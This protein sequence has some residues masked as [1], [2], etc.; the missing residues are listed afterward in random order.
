MSVTRIPLVSALAALLAPA[1]AASSGQDCVILL[2]G[3]AR[4]DTSLVP[5]AEVLEADGYQVENI[6]Y[7]S[8]QGEI[9]SLAETA[10]DG[11]LA[12]CGEAA[13]VHFVTHSMGG[14][15]VRAWLAAH[16]ETPVGHVVMMSPPNRGS[17]LVDVLES[18][19]L[20]AEINGPAGA[21]LQTGESST[22]AQLPPADYSL[23]IIA[24]N[25]TLNPIA[26]QIIAGPDDGKVSVASTRLDGMADH[27]TL[28]V[29]HT[30]MMLSPLV[31]EQVRT[32]LRTGA[33]D[34]D[35]TLAEA[36]FRL[37]QP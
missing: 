28:P 8:T 12:A 25:R 17:E 32:Y 2:H 26:S 13:T 16:P 14:I 15:L 7:P 24:G 35:L 20:F 3:L 19:P 4:T 37:S 9:A 5:M 6:G 11:A 10:V 34:H 1:V 27:V 21:E 31:I 36:A 18:W 33:F 22:P 29:T 30:F 23:G